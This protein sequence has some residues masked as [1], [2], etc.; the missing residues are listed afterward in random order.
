MT[1]SELGEGAISGV[2]LE[3][4]IVN[5]VANSL[6]ALELAGAQPPFSVLVALVGVRGMGM[7]NPHGMIPMRAPAPIDRNLVRLP[8]VLCETYA[9]DR[10]REMRPI[11]DALWQSSGW[12][13][14]PCYTATGDWNP[15]G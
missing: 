11:S 15:P 2:G 10:P 8:D 13:A 3:R 14:S 7:A 5:G 4:E 9:W 6:R 1:L 12:N